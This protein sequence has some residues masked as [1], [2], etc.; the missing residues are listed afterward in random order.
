MSAIARGEFGQLFQR[1]NAAMPNRDLITG[2]LIDRLG[3]QVDGVSLTVGANLTQRHQ[4]S[5]SDAAKR[6]ESNQSLQQ[7]G[8][9]VILRLEPIRLRE[10]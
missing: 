2:H 1:V 6:E 4:C 8:P 7:G 9:D 10:T 3:E 5:E